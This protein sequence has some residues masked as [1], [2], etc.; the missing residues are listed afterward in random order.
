MLSRTDRVYSR[1]GGPHRHV[2]QRLAA[3]AP[4]LR[5]WV[6]AGAVILLCGSRQGMASGVDAV[7]TEALGETTLQTLRQQ[8]RLRRDVY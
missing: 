1:D 2:Q 3:E 4:R 6:E 8:G 5:D 7:L